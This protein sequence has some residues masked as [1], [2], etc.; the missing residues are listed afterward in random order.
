MHHRCRPL[1]YRAKLS[2]CRRQLNYPFQPFTSTAPG[3]KEG[4][5]NEL[6]AYQQSGCHP[7]GARNSCLVA[8]GTTHFHP[9]FLLLQAE[10]M[11][12]AGP[13]WS[14]ACSRLCVSQLPAEGEYNDSW[15]QLQAG[16][17]LRVDLSHQVLFLLHSSAV[18]RKCS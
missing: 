2:C 14:Q 13:R 10:W 5:G 6:R 1:K 8:I 16:Q 12:S 11:S 9:S 3:W 18:Q 17:S 4:C 15:M 7:W